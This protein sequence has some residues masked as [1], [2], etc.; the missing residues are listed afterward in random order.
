VTDRPDTSLIEATETALAA[1]TDRV[2]II[3]HAG[4]RFVAKRT[5]PHSRTR[6]QAFF[7][8]WLV[9]WITGQSLPMKAL[10][11]SEAT[12]SVD[13]EGRRLESLANA[14]VRVPKMIHHGPGYLL[15][16]HCGATVADQ[17]DDWSIDTCRAELQREARELGIFHR[18]GQWHGAAQIKNLT[19][20]DGHTWRIDFEETFGELVPL[21]VVQA[22]DIVLFLNS[23]SLAGPIAEAE[24]RRLLPQLLDSCLAANPDPRVRE[25]LARAL[26]WVKRLA[27]LSAPLRKR[28]VKGRQRKGAARLALLA[29]ALSSVLET[30]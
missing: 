23:I 6:L 19:R 11:L 28:T 2:V 8:R 7:V 12:S 26:P 13:Y 18:A 17:L 27:W 5:A 21:P 25:T 15:L 24:S 10:R 20:K 16:E 22:L 9:K 4:R 3:D 1:S 30:R 29:E 14:G